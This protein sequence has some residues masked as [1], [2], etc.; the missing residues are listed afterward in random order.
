MG[1]GPRDL[2][3]YTRRAPL[4]GQ[5]HSHRRPWRAVAAGCPDP[6]RLWCRY[7]LAR[8]DITL[9]TPRRL[10]GAAGRQHRGKVQ[11]TGRPGDG[12][13]HDVHRGERGVGRRGDRACRRR[14]VGDVRSGRRPGRRHR[15]RREPHLRHHR[16]RRQPADRY[17]GFVQHRRHRSGRH[18][19]RVLPGR[20]RPRARWNR[21]RQHRQQQ[22]RRSVRR[23]HRDI[24]DRSQRGRA[25]HLRA[26]GDFLGIGPLLALALQHQ[27]S[28]P[29]LGPG[30]LG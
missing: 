24:R 11:R 25:R 15:L 29:G 6:D 7:H 20:R 21:Q 17:R 1:L 28:L 27:V 14:P 3:G 16:P 5:L 2:S 30:S 8:G 23:N 9:A 4:H 22:R 19:R 18:C 13:A 10:R 26:L 12:D